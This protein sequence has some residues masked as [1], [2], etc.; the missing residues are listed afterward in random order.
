M[1]RKRSCWI[2]IVSTKE[3]IYWITFF[4]WNYDKMK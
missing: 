4:K 1:Q 2:F 3:T